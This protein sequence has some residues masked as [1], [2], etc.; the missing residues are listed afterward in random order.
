MSFRFTCD[1]PLEFEASAGTGKS[2]TVT[3][4]YLRLLLE[5]NLTVDQILVVTF[6]DAATKELRDDIR[7]RI[8]GAL[9]AFEDKISE[10][11]YPDNGEYIQL[12]NSSDDCEASIRQLNRAK[13]S[14]DEAAVFTI[15][16]FCQRSLSENA[17]EACLPFASELMAD[18]SEIMQKLTDD[19]WRHFTKKAPKSL[20][21]KLQQKSVT[22]DSLLKDIKHVVGKPYLK[23]CGPLTAEDKSEKWGELESNFK[24]I[25]EQWQVEYTEVSKILL[26]DQS[27]NRRNFGVAKVTEAI[28]EMGRLNALYNINSDSIKLFEKFKQTYISD[29]I[30]AKCDAPTHPFFE[31]WEIFSNLWEELNKS[32]DDFLNDTRIELIEY[33]QAQLPVEKLRLGVL[34]FDDLLLQ[35]QKTLK[36]H[37]QLAKDLREKYKVALID[38]FQ[39]TDP[40]QYDIFHSIYK[41]SNKKDNAVFFVGDPKQ[42]I[43]SFRG[44][45]IF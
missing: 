19:F 5:K 23:I 44:R 38:E 32:S 16:S 17:F 14:M 2:W 37:P 12:I 40:I 25:T 4:L 45:G 43:Y 24:T 22:P 42:A 39:D 30:K 26:E 20:L 3:Y 35:L 8:V 7:E 36:T 28:V 6:T 33:L 11:G 13:L 29:H 18:D 31:N 10:K 21:F 27:L 34:S 1:P 9:Q 41:E 15:H